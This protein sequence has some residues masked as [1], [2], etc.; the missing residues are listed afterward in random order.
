MSTCLIGLGS[1]LGDRQGMLAEALARL[2]RTAGVEL[3]ARSPALETR[4]VGG[5]PGQG[6]Y[7]N[8]AAVLQTSLAPQVLLG[9]LQRIETDLGRRRGEPWGP[10]TI[11][12][13][14]LLYDRIV[15]ATP[16][17]VVPHPRM[18]WRRFVLEPA[19]RIAPAMIHPLLGWPIRRMLQHLDRSAWYVAIA[20]AAGAGKTALAR[21]VAARSGARLLLA[22]PDL[23]S[24]TRQDTSGYAWQIELE[25]L[26]LR[27]RE[28]SARRQQWRAGSPAVGDY[29]FDQS[30]A[31]AR[32]WLRPEQWEAYLA[33]WEEAQR[34]VVRPRLVVLLEVPPERWGGVGQFLL[35]QALKPN[36]G[37]LL[38][39]AAGDEQAAVRELLA[40]L[41]AMK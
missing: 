25:F 20:G 6:A 40:A 4:A 37:P 9:V 33:R 29:W 14:L 35:D 15:M 23:T 24:A 32:A 8:A 31:F 38:R 30:L 39:L 17:L 7:L 10:R 19:G 1:N 21:E 34:R 16:S 5:P 11:D 26:K 3:T 27:T 13:D 12:L 28:L 41:E 22:P 18:A 2:A 36:Q